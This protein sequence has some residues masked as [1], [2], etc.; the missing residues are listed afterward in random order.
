LT[1]IARKFSRSIKTISGQKQTGMRKLG[2]RNDF[3]LMLLR[4][5]L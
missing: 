1:E 5:N 3:E 2:I 4:N